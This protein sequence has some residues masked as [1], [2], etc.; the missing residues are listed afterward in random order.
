MNCFKQNR[1]GVFQLS[2]MTILYIV[3][4]VFFI[5][6]VL[7][8]RSTIRSK[9]KKIEWNY[10]ETGVISEK[11]IWIGK[12]TACPV[13][14]Y[15]VDGK[16][17]E[18]ESRLGQNPP[19]RVGKAVRVYYNPDNPEEMLID[20]FIQRGGLFLLLGVVF[21]SFSLIATWILYSIMK[22]PMYS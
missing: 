6:G 3:I 16:T 2:G 8:L 5:I 20:T 17:Y 18:V 4:P 7:F 15:A 19:L 21:I 11:R 1:K 22:S 10:T 9:M 12:E 13:V 14:Q